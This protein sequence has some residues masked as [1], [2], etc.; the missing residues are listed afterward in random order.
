M[1]AKATTPVPQAGPIK[2]LARKKARKR[3]RKSKAQGGSRAPGS[4]PAAVAGRPPKVPENFSQNWKAL[5][6]LLK[7]KSQAPEKTLVSQMDDKVHP[8]I[9]QQNKQETADKSKGE[10]KRTERD[11]TTRG[12]VTSTSKDRKILEPP[13]NSSGTEQK[14]GVKRRTYS[15][16]SSHQGDIK[17]KWKAKE[18]AVLN[19]STP[20]EEDIWFDD[21]DPDDIEAAIGPEAAMLVR[22][23]LGQSKKTISLVKEQAFGGLTKAL[24]LDC[25]MVGVGPKG[26]DSIAAR[27]SIVNQYGKCVY[28][29]YVK[30]TEPVTDYRTAVSGIRPE[31]LK[32]GEE[33]EVVKKEVAEML[34]G[35]ILVG[36][37]LHSDLKVLFLDHPKKKIRDTQK[38]K[39]FK[40]RVRSGRPS[41]KQLSEKILG[42]RVQQAEH[43]SVQD[44]QAAMRLYIMAKREWESITADRRPPATTPNHCSEYA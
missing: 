12:A 2:K 42:I 38:F 28:D 25:E 5:Q 37:A 18:A 11:R 14:K 33:F 24:A 16:I 10:R 44:A 32:Q 22:K 3:V 39:P 9:I 43:C 27:V 34:K 20:T 23:R 13:T 4:P 1:K 36:H 41:L 40:S 26:E 19:Q 35:R 29:K 6:E 7:Q 8:Q 21:V 15:D 31:N 30:P 17:H